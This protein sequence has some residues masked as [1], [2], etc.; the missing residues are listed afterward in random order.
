MVTKCKNQGDDNGNKERDDLLLL[1]NEWTE[2]G[3]EITEERKWA[4]SKIE[5]YEKWQRGHE[6]IIT[7]PKETQS[8]IKDYFLFSAIKNRRSIR[9]WKN[10]KVP[11]EI[12][13]KVIQ[14]GI[15]APSAFNRQPWKFYVIE[16]N[17]FSLREGDST[18]KSMFE[19]A[20]VRIY[21]AIDERLYEEEYAPALDAG[22]AIQNMLLAAHSVGLGACVIYQCEIIDQ[23]KLRKFLDIPDYYK[24]YSAILLGYPDEI[25]EK[26]ERVKIKDVV[27]FI[28]TE[29]ALESFL[30]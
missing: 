10:Q 2:R 18:N 27:K 6:K 16:N 11:G 4:E 24:I 8:L 25:P 26:P 7:K 17:N 21:I 20:P 19:K 14:A 22:L 3:Y 30:L 12:L 5:L 1:L 15:E 28:S 29:S 23:D 9:F 13:E